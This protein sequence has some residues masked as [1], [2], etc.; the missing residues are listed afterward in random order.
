MLVPKLIILAITA[1]SYT[2]G[3]NT[4]AAPNHAAVDKTE[5]SVADIQA[6]IT[7]NTGIAQ[8]RETTFTLHLHNKTNQQPITFNDLTEMHTKKIHL[9]I[10]DPSLTDYHHEHPQ[11]TAISGAYQFAFTPEK[12]GDYK[13]FVDITPATLSD[14][15]YLPV[16]LQ[17][18]GT[19]DLVVP[20]PEIKAGQLQ[21][22]Q[23]VDGLQFTT[24]IDTDNIQTNQAYQMHIEITDAN[25]QKPI[26]TLEPVMGAFAHMVGFSADR[27]EVMHAHPMGKEP[28]SPE[29]RGGPGLD[30]HAT[31]PTSGFYR[32]FVQV[33][34]AGKNIFVPLDV[35]VE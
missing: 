3:Y 6:G 21:K 10:I 11:P 12:A 7:P 16:D 13:A 1:L 2:W 9:L 34:M 5:K 8:G 19:P 14:N 31:F 29:E 35:Q 28:T 18:T 24:T 32:L 25:T 15:L 33:Q 22:S 26:T 4:W 20:N 23:T 27:N 17:V 30:F